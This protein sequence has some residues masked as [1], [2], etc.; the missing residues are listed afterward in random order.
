MSVSAKKEAV[1]A[2]WMG[3]EV[4][5]GGGAGG[6][7]RDHI[8]TH[9]MHQAKG[10]WYFPSLLQNCLLDFNIFCTV[11]RERKRKR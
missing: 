5:T 9:L 10:M 2:E 1:A 3:Y 11:W 7:R 4:S 6:G 8:G